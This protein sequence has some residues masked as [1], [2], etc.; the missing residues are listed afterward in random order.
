MMKQAILVFLSITFIQSLSAQNIVVEGSLNEKGT[1]EAIP[2]ATIIDIT[3][4]KYGTTS[5]ENGSFKLVLPFGSEENQVYFSALGFKDFTISV[6]ALLDNP[7]VTLEVD[8]F[9]LPD[10]IVTATTGKTGQI[11]NKE[12]AIF[13]SATGEVGFEASAGFSWGAYFKAGAKDKGILESIDIYI[14]DS[15]FPQA[16]LS[17]RLFSFSGEFQFYRNQSRSLFHDL[18]PETLVIQAK[19]SGWL[20]VNLTKYNI[21]MPE[22]GLYCLLSPLDEGS[23]YEYDTNYGTKYGAVIGI[24]S[25]KGD[26]KAVFPLIQSKDRLAVLKKQQ[27]QAPAMAVTFRK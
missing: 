4:N 1:N 13:K 19:G 2:F 9:I 26:A 11:G 12:G 14:T 16:P 10:V 17:L 3:S 24:Y 7:K 27:A 5:R 18:L 25:K 21:A 8:P 6:R 20:N 22:E 15:G 23:K